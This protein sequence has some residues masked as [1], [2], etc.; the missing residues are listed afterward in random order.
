[1]ALKTIR[2][3]SA[4]SIVQ[5]DD[6]DFDSA[7]E[8]DAPIKA[9]APSDPNDVLRLGDLP[10]SAGGITGSFTCIT[11]LR[12]GGFG[13]VEYKQRTIT[14]TAGVVTTIGAESAWTS[15]WLHCTTVPPTTAP[16]TTA[17]PTTVAPT[18]APPT[19]LAPTT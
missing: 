1:M 17:A 3:G 15:L 14:L 18:T 13:E 2:I 9:S 10:L 4:E 11:A 12:C 7:I 19:T 5:Y 16:P 6:A 8:V